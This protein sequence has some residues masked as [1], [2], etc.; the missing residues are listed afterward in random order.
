[1]T[2]YV[3]SGL[4]QAKE[5]GYTIDDDRLSNARKWL[6]TTL[7]AHPDMIPDLRAY[8]VYALATT[9]GAPK[10]ELDRAWSSAGKLSDEG[11]A[12]TGLA[13]DAAGDSRAHQAAEL[14]E[15]G[16]TQ[17]TLMRIGKAATTA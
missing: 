16:P 4:G 3:V 9:G 12:L 13:L 10:S 14:L 5:A 2:A 7:A 6:L 8:T 17:P 15:R 1:M 11:L